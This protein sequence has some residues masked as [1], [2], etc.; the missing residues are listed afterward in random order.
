MWRREGRCPRNK[1]SGSNK[2]QRAQISLRASWLGNLERKKCENLQRQGGD[3]PP[4]NQPCSGQVGLLE[5]DRRKARCEIVAM[6]CK[7][8]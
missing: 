3:N 5:F 6:K 7:V 8:V 1:R 2:T 4:N